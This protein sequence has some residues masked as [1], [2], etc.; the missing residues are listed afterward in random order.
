M[1]MTIWWKSP[2]GGRRSPK[3]HEQQSKTFKVAYLSHVST[4]V[5]LKPLKNQEAGDQ[6]YILILVASPVSAFLAL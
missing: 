2:A 5:T 1:S 4:N 6:I 3:R